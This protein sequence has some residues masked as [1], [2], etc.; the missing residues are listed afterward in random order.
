MSDIRENGEQPAARR[1]DGDYPRVLVINVQPFNRLT[2]TGITLGNL[3]RDWPRDR[4]A[5]IHQYVMPPDPAFPVRARLMTPEDLRLPKVIRRALGGTAAPAPQVG[6]GGASAGGSVGGKAALRRALPG[7]LRSELFQL[8]HLP[9][10]R[11]SGSLT[12]WVE[13]FRPDVIYTWLEDIAIARLA[14]GL[15][16]RCGTAIVPHFL[17]DWP[18]TR[19]RDS[20]FRWVLR[21]ALASAVRAVLSRSGACFAIGDT[22]AAEYE[23]RYGRHFIPLMNCI[24]PERIHEDEPPSR[25]GVRFVYTGHLHLD[26]PR[27]LNEI[28]AALAAAAAAENTSAELLV[29]AP[30]DDLG[31]LG[32]ALNQGAVLRLAGSVPREQVPAMHRDADCLVHVESFSRKTAEYARLSLSTK[33]PEY[34]AAG[35]P[36]LAYGPEELASLRYL[37][38]CGCGVVVS[39]REPAALCEALRPLLASPELRRRLGARGRQVARQR[40]N[41]AVERERLRRTLAEAAGT[42][43][44]A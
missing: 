38:Q 32:P 42:R 20:P 22:M 23:R 40:H 3:F 11:L 24:E 16:Q 41:A 35:R 5:Q 29:Y 1:Q 27:A 8:L 44:D 15:S 4:L 43:R 33:I 31:P 10:Y 17:D 39:E 13:A 9:G 36:I 14:A 21:P 28:A 34:M 30:A 25:Q 12:D 18:S 6:G 26:R 7:S 2:A 37:R 19:Y